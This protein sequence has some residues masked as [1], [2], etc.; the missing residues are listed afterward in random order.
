MSD[1]KFLLFV[2]KERQNK[3]KDV[4]F[5]LSLIKLNKKCSR[6]NKN[7]QIDVLFALEIRGRERE[8]V[9]ERQKRERE[10]EREK[11]RGGREREKW[12]EIERK[13]EK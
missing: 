5:I 9:R 7:N 11:K 8:I 3:I 10:R 1:R 4:V 12:R 6:F 13:R 2:K